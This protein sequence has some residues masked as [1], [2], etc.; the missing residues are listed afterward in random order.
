MLE[1]LFFEH[2]RSVGET[3]GEHL[4]VAGSFATTMIVA[5][6]ACL[7]HAVVPGFFAKTGSAALERLHGRMVLN[8]RRVVGA[9]P[10]VLVSGGNEPA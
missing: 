1:R 9:T 3:Y 7:V 10:A 6:I 8:R 4:L 2:P 5:G